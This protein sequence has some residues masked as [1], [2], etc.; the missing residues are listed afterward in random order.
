MT[1]SASL[2]MLADGTTIVN[3]ERIEFTGG[4]GADIVTGGALADRF[5]FSFTTNAGNDVFNGAGGNDIM[6]GGLGND[7]LNGGDD[8]DTLTGGA[9]KDSQTGGL[10]ND[11]FDFNAKT[12]S[13]KAAR[14]V[15]LDFKRGEDKIDLDSID[16]KSKVAGDQDFKWIGKAKFHH[17]AGELHF[18][19]H[20]KNVYV[21]GDID[22]NGKADFQI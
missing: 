2:Q 7:T 11:T 15:I 8:S 16:A 22:G 12:E 10:G 19:K 3:I 18:V 6:F 5:G 17:K 14:D 9:G 13:T 21:E 4:D 20:G 1:D